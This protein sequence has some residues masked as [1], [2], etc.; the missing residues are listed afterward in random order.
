MIAH[1]VRAATGRDFHLQVRLGVGGPMGTTVAGTLQVIRWLEAD[2]IDAIHLTPVPDGVL[3][4]ASRLAKRA[5]EI[6]VLRN[7][8]FETEA[9]IASA[10]RDGCS[11]AI[12]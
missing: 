6:P 1:A 2:G 8:R 3:A 5:V 9:Q 10:L 7:G 11:D 4:Q 12:T